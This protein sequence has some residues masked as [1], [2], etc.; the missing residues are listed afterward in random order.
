M[1]VR[2][3]ICIFLNWKPLILLLSFLA[4]LAWGGAVASAQ[5]DEVSSS[6]PVMAVSP[7]DGSLWMAAPG[8]GLYRLGRN[9]RILHY[10]VGSGHLKNDTIVSLAFD[11]S[12]TLYILDAAG[13]LTRYSSIEGFS[14]VPSIDGGIG[15]LSESAGIPYIIKDSL[16]YS[17]SGDAPELV[18]TLPFSVSAPSLPEFEY[19][20]EPAAESEPSEEDKKG[21]AL[22]SILWIALGLFLGLVLGFLLFRRK[23]EEEK[24]SEAPAPVV[25]APSQ[26]AAPAV[27]KVEPVVQKKEAPVVEAT[28]VKEEEVPAAKEESAPLGIEEALKA[29][30]FGQKVWD[31]VIANLSNP[32]YGVEQ[33]AADLEIS[34]IHVNRKLKAQTGYSPSAVF[35]FIRMNHASR[36]LLEGK[37]TIADVAR[38]CGFASAS[39]FSTAFKDYYKQSPSEYV[40]G[41][42]PVSGTLDL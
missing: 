25:V 11:A 7:E 23:R 20:T 38:E 12:A 15:S 26:K 8:D 4:V 5:T 9:G 1:H 16:L 36:L 10:S 19:E 32:A 35:K 2:Y 21:S 14:S 34:R 6:S 27:Q 22:S 17:L 31:L 39:Y 28:P 42:S 3:W 40:A 29:S 33:V 30:E 37:L 24:V 13:Q 18:R 41:K